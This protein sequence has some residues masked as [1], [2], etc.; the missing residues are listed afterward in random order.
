MN[1]ETEDIN[2][3]SVSSSSAERQPTTS[4]SPSE[5]QHPDSEL[6]GSDQATLSGGSYQ[7]AD[8]LNDD[9]T[10]ADLLIDTTMASAPPLISYKPPSNTAAPNASVLKHLTKLSSGNFVSWKRDLEIHL[11]PCGLGT[12]IISRIPE[13]TVVTDIPVW[14][15]H[16]AQVL[17]AMRTT[18]D[19]HNLNA[20]S[21][22]QHPHDA[23]TILSRR[24]GHGENVGLAVANSI[25]AIVFQKFDASIS[26]EEF[27]SNTQSL[28]NELSELTTAHPGFKLS[29]EILALL[30]V[31]KLPRDTFNS[32]I[33]QLLSDLKNLTTGAV[34]D[35][36]LTESQS[37][38]P[39]TDDS[40]VAL[41]VQQ[42]PKKAAKGD[43]SSKDPSALCHLPSH[44][45]SMHS[46]SECRMQNPSLQP[47]RS[48]VPRPMGRTSSTPTN[49]TS[50][51][52]AA[53]SSLS[54]A[55]KA[56]LFDHLHTAQANLIASQ[57][58]VNEPAR[59][60]STDENPNDH[61]VYFANA[62]S[63]IAQAPIKS[64]EMVSDTGA[65]RFIF[66]TLEQ[67]ANLRPIAPVS[68]KTADG[69]CHLTAHYAEDTVVTSQDEHNKSHQMLLPNTL[70]CPDVSINL[71]P[72]SR[73][74][75]IGA[76]FSGNSSRMIY[77]NESTGEQ[78]HAVRR[79]HTSDLWAVRHNRQSTC[80]SVSSDL[81][82][83][84]M[85]H[86]HSSA[87]RRF[88]NSSSKSNTICTSCSL[89]KSD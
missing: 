52:L 5:N 47:N 86:L 10:I 56:R 59:T 81:M 60:S 30:L 22:A 41:A 54:D 77:K 7:S 17:L 3:T 72:A 2:I 13:P 33:Q 82:H 71:I 36:L 70:H 58:T 66:H 55:D 21:G 85:G 6:L 29:D 1:E 88:C 78:L 69:S 14:R 49:S 15:M 68:I 89:A 76:T 63:A 31:I 45:L 53:I 50:R 11:D 20:I 61:V 65:D 9:S 23:I 34:F 46:N 25:S 28:H 43:R 18:V 87:L 35:R 73:L 8:S 39:V 32:I 4:P 80:L 42:K 48:N 26:I 84:R 74:C 57:S 19:G 38:K 51:G 27:V 64:D 12:F 44:S 75:D 67:F 37:M 40:S 83:Q 24:H 79:P 16:R 62:Y